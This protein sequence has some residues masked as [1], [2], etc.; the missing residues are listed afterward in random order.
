MSAPEVAGT[1]AAASRPVRAYPRSWLAA[2]LLA[3]GAVF[4]GWFGPIQ[5]LLPAQAA[6]LAEP[7]GKEALLALVT[8]IGAVVSLVANPVWGVISDRLS[9]TVPRRRTVLV[10]GVLIGSAGLGVLAVAGDAAGMIAGWSLVQIGLNGP[11]AA[12][13]AMIADRV[14]AERRGLVGALFGVA[15]TAGV[16]LG[17]ATAV[18]AGEGALGYVVLA[19]AVP[20]LCIAIV[21]MPERRLGENTDAVPARQSLG[22]VLRALR[23]TAS[24]TWAWIVRLLL[25]LANALVLTYLYYFLLDMVKVDD[26][27]TWVLVLTG[28]NVLVTAVVASV[29][30]I[31]SDRIAKRRVFAL[32]AILT[33]AVGV[34]LIAFVPTLPVLMATTVLLGIGWGLYMAVDIAII[35]EVLPS[36]RSTASMLGLANIAAAL[37]QVLAPALAAPIVISLGGYS[38]LYIVTAVIA[39]LALPALARLRTVA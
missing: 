32:A 21:L 18:V 16:V 15:Q 28:V 29:G 25:N 13:I 30:G 2:L 36:D 4:A 23:P 34:L 39:L 19:V 37:P 31:W 5:I 14:P 35:T 20:L 12:L 10:A 8:G 6:N 27:G 3:A 11:L 26:P 1:A 38:V 7:G 17:T 24:F 33:V 9:G 22:A